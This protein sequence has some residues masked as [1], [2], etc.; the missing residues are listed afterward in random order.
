MF[1]AF[2]TQIVTRRYNRSEG[3]FRFSGA[4]GAEVV[5]SYIAPG[6]TAGVNNELLNPLVFRLG[7]RF[8]I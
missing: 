1:N 7:L 6:A 8:E 4:P 3:T 5:H 2:N